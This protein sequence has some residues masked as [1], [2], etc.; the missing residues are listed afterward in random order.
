MN[1]LSDLSNMN[2]LWPL[3]FHRQS[4]YDNILGKASEITN[5]I[6]PDA[7]E[8]AYV[9]KHINL[10]VNSVKLL[11][12]L[13]DQEN[14]EGEF[15]YATSLY[16]E[17]FNKLKSVFCQKKPTNSELSWSTIIKNH[18]N[19]GDSSLTITREKIQ[20]IRT[21]LLCSNNDELFSQKASLQDLI[22]KL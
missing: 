19:K 10:A 21:L 4:E 15:E 3:L 11:K 17:I 13:G 6:P 12:K 2:L 14:S 5:N 16:G 18:S 20:N 7:T 8:D 9:K 22:D 1:Y